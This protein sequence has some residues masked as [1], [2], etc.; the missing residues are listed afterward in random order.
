MVNGLT[1]K[2]DVAIRYI[3][4]ISFIKGDKLHAKEESIICVPLSI[5]E[6]QKIEKKKKLIKNRQSKIK[7]K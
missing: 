7:I 4:G 3:E 6:E 1:I 5:L 2:K